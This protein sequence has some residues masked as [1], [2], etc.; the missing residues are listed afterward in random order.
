MMRPPMTRRPMSKTICVCVIVR[1]N[2]FSDQSMVALVPLAMK[3]H[4]W[5]KETSL[6]S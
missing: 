4:E 3:G 2:T 5:L 1:L 6:P